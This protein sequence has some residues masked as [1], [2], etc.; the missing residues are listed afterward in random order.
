MSERNVQTGEERAVSGLKVL[1]GRMSCE[2]QL[3]KH[4]ARQRMDPPGPCLTFNLIISEEELQ[5]GLMSKGANKIF[6][7]LQK[8]RCHQATQ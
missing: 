7:R 3:S 8:L 6:E 2:N 5:G 4:V 1:M